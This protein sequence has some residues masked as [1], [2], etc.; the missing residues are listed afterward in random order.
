VTDAD[1]ALS[2]HD[3]I[4]QLADLQNRSTGFVLA[5]FGN[6]PREI[7]PIMMRE[8][9]TSRIGNLNIIE[10]LTIDQPANVEQFMK[11]LLAELV[12]QDDAESRINSSGLNSTRDIFP[13]EPSAFDQFCTYA[14]ANPGDG[15]P[16]KIISCLNECAID[17][18]TADGEVIDEATV[19][20]IA[21]LVFN[22]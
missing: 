2:V 12:D 15:T 11:E 6:E 8:D 13:F 14:T 9:V 16:R 5:T 21:P 18:W 7:P 10:I 17:V 19:D 22:G 20:K 1:A 3:L 4:R